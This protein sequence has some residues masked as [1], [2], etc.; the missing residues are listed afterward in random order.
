MSDKNNDIEIERLNGE[1]KLI[2]QKIDTILH[3]HLAHMQQDIDKL[4]R[5]VWTV[6]LIVFT[7]LIFIVRDVFF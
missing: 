5:L 2:N 3:N 7:N 6:G 1:I 4:N